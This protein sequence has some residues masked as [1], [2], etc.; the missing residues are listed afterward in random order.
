MRESVLFGGF[1]AAFQRDNGLWAIVQ[2]KHSGASWLWRR[3]ILGWLL[4]CVVLLAPLAYLFARRLT[5]PIAAFAHAAERL[6]RN[7]RA[8][9]LELDGPAEVRTAVTAFN[10]MQER[11]ARYV[12]DRTAMIGAIAHDLRTPLTRMRFLIEG[13]PGPVQDKMSREIDEMDAMIAATLAF[14]KDAS[15]GGERVVLDL[16]SLVESLASDLG[17]TG[18][19]VVCDSSPPILVRGDPLA[20]RRLFGNLL[21]N[22]LKFAGGAQV[23]IGQEGALA[24][25]IVSDRGPGLPEAELERAFEPFFRAEG[26]RNRET[27]GIG[28]GL[29]VV[30][31]VARAHGGDAALVN[32]P[33]GGLSCIVRVPID[34]E[35]MAA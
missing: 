3:R 28:L 13:Q 33:G 35:A 9:A 34:A 6:G 31:S 29:A 25:V 11:L 4:A 19:D 15:A 21:T 26:S 20:L 10:Q 7:P 22:A 24:L 1:T 32:R 23:S 18:A 2:P 12:D 16:A 17:E 14:V 5:S 27:G 30:R 8:A